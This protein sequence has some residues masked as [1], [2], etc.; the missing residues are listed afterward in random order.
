[1]ETSIEVLTV[2][3][4]LALTCGLLLGIP[5]AAVRMRSP[6]ASRHLVHAHIEALVAG[7]A[8]LALSIAAGYST[9]A[10]GAETLAAWLLTAGVAASLAGGT[11][12]WLMGSGDQFAERTPGYYLQAVSGPLMV[13]GGLLLS[14]GVLKELAG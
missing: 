9:L 2:A 13:I 8:L 12:N 7:A 10:D 6:T 14:A 4:T 5:L 1:M 11:L 3:G